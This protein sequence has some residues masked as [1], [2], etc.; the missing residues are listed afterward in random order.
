MHW[1][2]WDTET[3]NMVGD[4]ATEAAALMIVRDA[5]RRHGTAIAATLALGAEYDDEGGADDD[6]PPVLHG[7]ELIS[8]ARGERP[9]EA[10][11]SL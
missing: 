8:R 4:Y 2:L 1:E 3:G 9:D 7:P 10:A 5:M 11:D 6:L